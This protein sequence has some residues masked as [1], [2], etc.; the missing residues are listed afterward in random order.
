MGRALLLSLALL[1]LAVAPAAADESVEAGGLTVT[2]TADPWGL[3]FR[4]A[5]GAV[6]TELGSAGNGPTGPLGFSAGGTW[7]HA[8][9]ATSMLRDGD[10][11]SATLATNDPR[12]PRRSS[13]RIRPDGDGM[14]AVEA[15]RRAARP[16]RHSHR[17]RLP[18]RRR[19]ALPRLRRALATRST[20][21]ATT[22]R[23]T[24]SDGPVPASRAPADRRRSCRRRASAPRDDATY[25]PIPW[26]LSTRGYGVLV[27]NDETSVL[28]PRRATSPDAWSAEVDGRRAARCASSP[29]PQPADVAARASARASGRQPRG[30]GA[31]LLRPVVPAEG[32]RRGRT[33]DDAAQGRTRR[34]RSPRPTRTTCRAA[35]SRARPTRERARTRAAPRRRASRS[36]RTSTR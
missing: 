16:G 32:R 33:I 27:D 1:V 28:P 26:L 2:A 7:F 20:S 25:F 24:S 30:R 31:V 8:T 6:L 34:P 35:T 23:T 10:T 22:S 18:R 17:R 29:G 19:R 5:R 9:R 4:D 3:T 15:T 21:A 11:V 13:V 14:I 12:G 36:R